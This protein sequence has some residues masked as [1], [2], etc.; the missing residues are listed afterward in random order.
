MN[1]LA[2][3][4]FELTRRIILQGAEKV[5]RHD[6]PMMT[7]PRRYR[8]CYRRPS[9]FRRRASLFALAA[10]SVIATTLAINSPA[11]TAAA[12]EIKGNVS[13]QTGERIYHVPGQAYYL[14]TRV[15]ARRSERWFCSE[16]EAVAA[17]WRRARR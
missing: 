11:Q 6:R 2:L 1:G 8:S 9:D 16:A 3:A 14:A 15:D 17:G 7:P 13:A 5:R 4:Q 10:A 12:C